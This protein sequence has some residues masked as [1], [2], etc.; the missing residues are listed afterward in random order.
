VRGGPRCRRFTGEYGVDGIADVDLGGLPV[1]VEG[2]VEAAV[3]GK[4]PAIP[5]SAEQERIGV[6]TASYAA[7]AS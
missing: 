4:R 2:V 7:A 1:R 3:I 6:Q 5:F